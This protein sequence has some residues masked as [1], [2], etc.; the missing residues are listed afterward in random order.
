MEQ[1][2][3]NDVKSATISL[4]DEDHTLAN[5]VHFTLNQDL[6]VTFCGYN[7]P[8][9]IDAKVNKRVQTTGL[10]D[11]Q[12]YGVLRPASYGYD[13]WDKR[14]DDASAWILGNWLTGHVKYGLIGYPS[15]SWFVKFQRN[16]YL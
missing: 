3:I 2:S 8:H 15:L 4:A 6:R 9:P 13:I 14:N 7:I 16:K 5:S 11:A 12:R 1:G 10:R